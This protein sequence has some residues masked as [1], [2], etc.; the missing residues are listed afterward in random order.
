MKP[1]YTQFKGDDPVGYVIAKNIARRHL[2]KSQKALAVA[3]LAT[4]KDGRPKLTTS[5]GR[6]I[7]DVAKEAGV[8]PSSIDRAKQVLEHGDD[9]LI[10]EVQAG[11]KTVTNFSTAG[12]A[13]DTHTEFK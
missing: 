8:S 4:L 5:S 7:P 11:D 6:S 12:N 1:R 10:K 2:T 9:D 3:G 13:V